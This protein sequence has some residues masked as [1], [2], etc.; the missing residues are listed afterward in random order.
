[1]TEEKVRLGIDPIYSLKGINP[2]QQF[3]FGLQQAVA[4]FGATVLV[5]LLTGLNVNTTLLMAG[6]GTL[7]F[8]VIT[9]FKVPR[10]PW[11]IV[12]VYCR[13]QHCLRR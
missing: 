12:C 9:G 4:M 1:M 11:I 3:I 13:L 5:P 7:L 10:F 6:L 2:V 8:H